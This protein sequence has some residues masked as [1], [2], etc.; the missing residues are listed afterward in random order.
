VTR[1]VTGATRVAAIIGHPIAHSRSPAIWNAG[2]DA[3]GLDWVFVALPVAP[4]HAAAAL[5][6][7]RA[8]RLAGITVT[9]PHKSDAA[10]AC[11]ELSETAAALGAVNAVVARDDRLLGDSTDGEG[12]VRSLGDEGV[13]IDGRRCLVLGAGG[14]A[15]AIAL[16][17]GAAG[18][19]VVVAARRLEAAVD[20]AAL[21]GGD[22]IL[23]SNAGEEV[24]GADLVV[25]ATPIGMQGEPPPVD[26]Q[27]LRP[28]VVVVD[29]VYHP[30]ATP[31][32]AAARARGMHA[33]NGIGMLVQQAA[34][35]FRS[36]TGV[37]APLDVMRAAAADD[38]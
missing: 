10:L 36:F 28:D 18:G 34:I 16:G 24:E 3:A 23:L 22:A 37:E 38:S 33:V 12:L 21:A 29:T 7:A 6:S 26:V 35:S 17:L 2:F 31:L 14:A 15:R 13:A 20:A 27:L 25:N 19:H 1:R 32:V 9:M 4:G 11:D 30:A 5:E 8:L